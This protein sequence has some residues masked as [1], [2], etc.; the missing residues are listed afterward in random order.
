M[1]PQL[2]QFLLN[3]DDPKYHETPPEF[4]WPAEMEK[5]QRLAPELSRIAGQD[6]AVDRTVQDASF[7]TELRIL[8]EADRGDRYTHY[9]RAAVRFSAFGRMVTVWANPGRMLLDADQKRRILEVLEREGYRYV[10]A[11]ALDVPYTGTNPHI[12]TWWIRFFDYL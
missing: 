1:D 11:E 10:P 9:I 7:F 8:E 3:L 6:F 4:D 2:L 5:V 12:A